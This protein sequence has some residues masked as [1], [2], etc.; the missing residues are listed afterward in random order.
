MTQ[1][2]VFNVGMRP[3]LLVVCSGD[4]PKRFSIWDYMSDDKHS[5]DRSERYCG[6]NKFFFCAF[7]PCL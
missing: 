7:M 1:F 2:S 6:E 4:G 3:Q 5:Y